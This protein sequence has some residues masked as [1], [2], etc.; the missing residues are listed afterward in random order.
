[1]KVGLVALHY[2][3]PEHRDEMISRVRRAAE[4]VAA[5]RGCL[6]VDCWVSDDGQTVVTT[7]QWKSERA[8]MA[9]FAA[10]QNAGVDF[11]YDERESRPREVVRLV[12]A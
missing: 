2:P 1:M 10:V 7:G 3:R 5:T 8:L 9:G 12:S 6:S 4:V 11:D